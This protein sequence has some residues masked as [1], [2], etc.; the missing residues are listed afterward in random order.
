MPAGRICHARYDRVNL[1]LAGHD[2]SAD[3]SRKRRQREIDVAAARTCILTVELRRRRSIK[4]RTDDRLLKRGR[5]PASM[6]RQAPSSPTRQ[7]PADA[8]FASSMRSL[9]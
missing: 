3:P 2:T 5:E 8:A 9:T 6:P 4:G 7:G 1:L